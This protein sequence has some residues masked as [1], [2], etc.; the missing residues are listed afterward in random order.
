[1]SQDN[2]TKRTAFLSGK[3][4][5]D[6]H[7]KNKFFT[8]AAELEAAGFTVLNPAA[9]PADAFS[10]DAYLRITEAM[11]RECDCVFFLPDWQE[12]RGARYEY[13]LAAACGKVGYFYDDFIREAHAPKVA[14]GREVES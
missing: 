6:P 11:L 3:I 13:G 10:W 1:M 7:Y 4:T 5:N 9:L 2:A 8:A 14:P 12:S